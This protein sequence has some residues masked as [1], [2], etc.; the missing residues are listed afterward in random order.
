[1][2]QQKIIHTCGIHVYVKSGVTKVFDYCYFPL[3]TRSRVILFLRAVHSFTQ[4][5]PL[6]NTPVN[7]IKISI[8]NCMPDNSKLKLPLVVAILQY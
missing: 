5:S 6:N 3:L 7:V 2:S 1:M 4:G 8:D